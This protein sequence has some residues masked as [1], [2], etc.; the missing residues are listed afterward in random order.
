[1]YNSKGLSDVWFVSPVIIQTIGDCRV[2]GGS[3][4]STSLTPG[5]L[6]RERKKNGGSQ[7]VTEPVTDVKDLS[8]C[9]NPV[10]V[11][12][13]DDLRGRSLRS[14]GGPTGSR[15]PCF[16]HSVPS[17]KCSGTMS[18]YLLA[19]TSVVSHSPRFGTNELGTDVD[20]EPHRVDNALCRE[21][22]YDCHVG[23]EKTSISRVVG[24][25]PEPQTRVGKG[26]GRQAS[27]VM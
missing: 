26:A 13:S 4:L 22:P 24:H 20:V 16:G 15:G 3:E 27:D 9:P 12:V 21:S 8:E 18:R 23:T 17:T 19:P 1:M 7:N 14:V 11:R 10:T 5:T 6:G 2:E 25:C